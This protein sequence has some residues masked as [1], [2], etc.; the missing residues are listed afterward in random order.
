MK[1]AELRGK[2]LPTM[3]VPPGPVCRPVRRAW[4]ELHRSSLSMR[5]IVIVLKA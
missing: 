3:P 4:Q 5:W 2:A 1:V